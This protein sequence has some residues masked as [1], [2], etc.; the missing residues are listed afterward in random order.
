VRDAL[1]ERA[2]APMTDPLPAHDFQRTFI[3]DLLEA[4]EDLSVAQ[5]MA[6][7]A[8]IRT[9]AKYDHRGEKAKEQA[10]SKLHIPAIA[11]PTTMPTPA[12][13]REPSRSGVRP[14]T[15]DD[16]ANR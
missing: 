2:K 1:V 9:T 6:G 4:G 8:D 12:A 13:A 7:H 16:N 15:S 10:A 5:K 3:S 14:S 11:P